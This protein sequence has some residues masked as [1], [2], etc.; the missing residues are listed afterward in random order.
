VENRVNLMEHPHEAAVCVHVDAL[1]IL[2]DMAVYAVQTTA[3]AS[4][5]AGCCLDPITNDFKY[6]G[7]DFGVFIR[8][9]GT[10]MAST[11]QQEPTAGL[12]VIRESIFKCLVFG[13]VGVWEVVI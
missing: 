4:P 11:R 9:V 6:L 13:D 12:G 8:T 7:T 2:A 5:P 1:G 10:A 3:Q